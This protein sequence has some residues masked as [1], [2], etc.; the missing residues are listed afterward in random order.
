MSANLPALEGG[1]PVHGGT[2]VPFFRSL[3]S[4]EDLEAVTQVLR[5]GWL[6]LGPR[7]GEFESACAAFLGTPHAVATNSCTSALFLALRAANIGAG[8]E[9]VVP[10][11]TFPA[12]VHVIR[13][14]GAEPVLADIEMQSFGLDASD[15]VFWDKGL[16]MIADL[17]D[18]LE[19]LG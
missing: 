1:R 13:H 19:T 5:S 11:L 8:D 12:T 2:A 6:T 14:V 15:P 4:E 16:D 17:I 18:E 3:L 9:V 10:S 7:T